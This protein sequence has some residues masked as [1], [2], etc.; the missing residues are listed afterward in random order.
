MAVDTVSPYLK[1][2]RK[3]ARIIGEG[4]VKISG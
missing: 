2:Q 1:V 4:A 3:S